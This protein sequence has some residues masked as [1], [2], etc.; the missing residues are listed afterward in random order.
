[1]QLKQGTLCNPDYNKPR[2]II[3]GGQVSDWFSDAE[4]AE[5]E[6]EVRLALSYFSPN[7]KIFD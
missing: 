3:G 7:Y 6:Q 4:P 1:M 5:H 2:L